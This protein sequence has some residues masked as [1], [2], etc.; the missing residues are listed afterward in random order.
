MT[1]I[2]MFFFVDWGEKIKSELVVFP[3]SKLRKADI[4][5]SEHADCGGRINHLVC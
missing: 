3:L 4:N 2:D 5:H 1:I